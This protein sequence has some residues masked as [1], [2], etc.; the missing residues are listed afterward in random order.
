MAASASRKGFFPNRNMISGDNS[1][2][3]RYI[4]AASAVVTIGDAIDI[5]T[6]P[7]FAGPAT[8]TSKVAGVVVGIVDKNGINIFTTLGGPT[9]AGTRS[10]DD[11]YTAASTNKTVDQVAV[12]IVPALEGQLFYNEADS[13]LTAA[14]VS[15]YFALTAT[16][17]QVTGTGDGTA[18]TAQL[19]EIISLAG[20]PNGFGE[21][22]FRF[23]RS[24]WTNEV[25]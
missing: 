12:E 8:G 23:S 25:A 10:G 18:R 2:V 6:D 11:T 4:V 3:L 13:T 15:R 20:G 19:V 22:L 14:E 9:V 17:D 16:G 21:G 1:G 5:I 7:G 24:Q